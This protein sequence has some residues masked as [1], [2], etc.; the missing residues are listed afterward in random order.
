MLIILSSHSPTSLLYLSYDISV[1]TD[2][3]RQIGLS[4][5]SF[6]HDGLIFLLHYSLFKAIYYYLLF[7]WLSIIE[8]SLITFTAAIGLLF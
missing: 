6:R 8:G 4:F 2:A 3:V 7:Q 5:A 1:V